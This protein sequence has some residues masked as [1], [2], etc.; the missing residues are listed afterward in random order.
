M[1]LTRREIGYA[2]VRIRIAEV[3]RTLTAPPS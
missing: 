3:I 1:P 2:K